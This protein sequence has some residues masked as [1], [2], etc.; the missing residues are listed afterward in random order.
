MQK[1]KKT[2]GEL[3]YLRHIPRV[4]FHLRLGYL[5]QANFLNNVH[6]K[7]ILLAILL[8]SAAMEYQSI[9]HNFWK[10]VPLY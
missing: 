4:C 1:K 10:M 2:K 7:I 6:K 8:E 3:I 9:T 5:A